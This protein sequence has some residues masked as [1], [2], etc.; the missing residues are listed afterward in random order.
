MHLLS[1]LVFPLATRGENWSLRDRMSE[2]ELLDNLRP[3]LS[4]NVQKIA[5]AERKNT[6]LCDLLDTSPPISNLVQQLYG[7]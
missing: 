4:I 7:L 6:A 5:R 1:E 2:C 3:K